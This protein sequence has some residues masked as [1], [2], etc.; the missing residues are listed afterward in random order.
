[1]ILQEKTT[2]MKRITILYKTMLLLFTV[3]CL[4]ACDNDVEDIPKVEE[5]LTLS[6]SSIDIVL[7][8]ENP[9]ADILTFTWTAARQL[10]DDYIISYETKMDVLGNNFGSATAILAYEDEGVFSKSFTSEQLQN[11]ANEKWGLPV[12]KPFTLEFRVVAQWEGGPTFESP[13]VRTIAVNVQPIKTIVFDADNIFLDGSA[14]PGTNKVEISK[15]LENQNQYAY[16][17]NLDAGDLQIPVEFNGETNYICPAD[18][19]GTLQDGELENVVMRESP[20]A[21]KIPAAGEYRIVVNMEKATVAIYSPNK[22]LL[23]KTVEWNADGGI[24]TTTEIT[25]LWMH[26]AINSWGAPIQC[27]CT[28][29]LADPQVLVYTGGQTGKAKFIVYGGS[30]NNKNLAYAFSCE[31][32]SETDGQ[33]LSLTLGKVADLY[34]GYSRGQRNSYYTIPTGANFVVFDLRNMTIIAEKR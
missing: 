8:G 30:D 24:P 7:D 11:W 5:H 17:L 22:A 28:V 19:E 2:F 20:V 9:T 21:W 32:K 4:N 3:L 10:P 33:E 12:N 1:M 31:P 16:L 18:G 13:E 23:P 6:A 14:V 34:G 25:D 27:N 29:S 26:G 15:T